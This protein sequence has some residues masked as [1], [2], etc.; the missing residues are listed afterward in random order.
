MISARLLEKLKIVYE[1][2]GLDGLKQEIKDLK[3]HIQLMCKVNDIVKLVLE[4]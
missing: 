1:D 2:F 3:I 4:N